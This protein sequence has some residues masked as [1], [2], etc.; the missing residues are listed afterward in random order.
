MHSARLG[1]GGHRRRK[2]Y[3]KEANRKC[4]IKESHPLLSASFL[5]HPHTETKC[6]FYSRFILSSYHAVSV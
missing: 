6:R 1:G 5:T 2:K 3:K 4:S